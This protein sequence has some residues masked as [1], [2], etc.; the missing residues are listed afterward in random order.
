MAAGE[1]L[2][3]RWDT[4]SKP[5]IGNVTQHYLI[6]SIPLIRGEKTAFQGSP[7]TLINGN[8]ILLGDI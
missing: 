3:S 8:N 7:S 2:P 5:G 1:P 4:R 6:H